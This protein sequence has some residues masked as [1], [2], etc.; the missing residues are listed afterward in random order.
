MKPYLQL[1]RPHQYVKNTFIFLP[2]FFAIK[3]DQ[4]DLL[5]R[6]ILAFGCFCAVASGVYIFNDYKDIASDQQHP[7]KKFRPLAS[8][9]VPIKA[10]FTLMVI[11]LALGGGIAYWLTPYFFLIIFVYF[12]M[13]LLYSLR[14]KHIAIVDLFIIATG[15]VLRVFAGAIVS[16]VEARMWIILMTFLL[17]LF[18][19]LA[20]RRDDVLLSQQGAAVRKSI[21]GYN[22]E[23]VNA[24]M[25]TMAPVI[26]VAYISYTISPEVTERFH[27][28]YLYL[29][30]VFVI[31]GIL[32]YLQLTLVHN[33]SGNPT[34]ILLK[35]RFLQITIAAWLFSF[36]LLIY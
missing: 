13:N 24:G 3:I 35:D 16:N 32:R 1:L 36:V 29:T 27:T 30:V 20:K 9:T 21:D 31:L 10:A 11:L 25:F 2:L 18:L 28:Q 6:N 15:F 26:L 7:T 34:E 4:I 12:L 14:L 19:G 22:L 17:A 5:L 23:F 8:G 33:N